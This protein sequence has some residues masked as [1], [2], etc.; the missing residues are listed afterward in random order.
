[1]QQAKKYFVLTWRIWRPVCNVSD[2]RKKHMIRP[3]LKITG[4]S[5]YISP[6]TK[7]E[8]YPNISRI[9][10]DSIKSRPISLARSVASR[11]SSK[12]NGFP[13]LAFTYSWTCN[14]KTI[15][16][17]PNVTKNNWSKKNQFRG[18]KKG[19]AW[20]LVIFLADALLK[21]DQWLSEGNNQV[22]RL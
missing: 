20:Y 7:Y 8:P 19:F 16:L 17:F 4:T 11:H 6:I 21:H 2:A 13:P 5:Y 12:F 18:N 22:S 15:P 3:R 1:M 9:T 10:S 14:W